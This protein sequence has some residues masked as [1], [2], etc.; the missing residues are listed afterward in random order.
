MGLFDDIQKAATDTLCMC[1]TQ[2]PRVSTHLCLECIEENAR[3]ANYTLRA[4]LPVGHKRC[5]KC[6]A[7]KAYEDFAKNR[8]TKDGLQHHCKGCT[9]KA[10][11]EYQRKRREALRNVDANALVLQAIEAGCF[12]HRPL[13]KKEIAEGSWRSE[14]EKVCSTCGTSRTLDEYAHDRYR[15]DGL[16][17]RCRRCR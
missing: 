8:A 3:E 7:T 5:S 16:D 17:P 15:P 9:R 11:R 2:R 4:I 1:C 10:S 12:E 13:S 6:G 14:W